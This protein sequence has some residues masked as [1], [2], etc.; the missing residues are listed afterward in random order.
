MHAIRAAQVKA[1]KSAAFLSRR[2][3][4]DGVTSYLETLDTER[5]LFNAEL[6]HSAALER[7]LNSIVQLYRAL[8]GGW[9]DESQSA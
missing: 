9:S 4:M 5:S 7:Y 1:G 6:A 3:Y 2:R 8:G